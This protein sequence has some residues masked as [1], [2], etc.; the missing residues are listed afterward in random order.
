MLCDKYW[1]LQQGTVYHGLIQVTTV[2]RKQGPD[3]FV[4]TINLRQVSKRNIHHLLWYL[5]KCCCG[6]V[7]ALTAPVINQRRRRSLCVWVEGKCLCFREIVQL[8]G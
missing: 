3:Y 6:L 1:P 5:L 8:T 2:I 7:C 4:T